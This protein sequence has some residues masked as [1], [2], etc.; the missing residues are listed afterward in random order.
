VHNGLCRLERRPDGQ[1]TR[2]KR[3]NKGWGE[4]V[5]TVPD[6]ML[7]KAVGAT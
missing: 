3:W 2:R 7:D 6:A 4:E 5:V 1:R